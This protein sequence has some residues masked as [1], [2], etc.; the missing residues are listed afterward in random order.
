LAKEGIMEKIKAFF[1]ALWGIVK[2]ICVEY[3]RQKHGNVLDEEEAD[4]E[5]ITV[6]LK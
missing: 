1:L 6:N 3:F 2:D 4:S 5:K